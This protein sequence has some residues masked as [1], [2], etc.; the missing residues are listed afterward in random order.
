MLVPIGGYKMAIK[1]GDKVKIDYEGRLED[2]T[3]FDSSS[4][5]GAPLQVEVGA[6]Q[7]IPGFEKALVGMEKGQEK[8]ITL[9]PEEA[10]GQYRKEL[11]QKVPKDRLPKEHEPKPGMM[12]VLGTPDG[13]QMPAKIAEVGD[14]DVTIDINHPLAGKTLIFKIKIV[15]IL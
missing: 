14:N 5:H 2:G 4:K 9:K 13:K 15:E 6:H 8:E 1:E 11:L 3:V 12:L 10:Y 7:V